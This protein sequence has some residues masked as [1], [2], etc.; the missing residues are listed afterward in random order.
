MRTKDKRKRWT[1]GRKWKVRRCIKGR[2]DDETM[3]KK[4]WG[5]VNLVNQCRKKRKWVK[6]TFNCAETKAGIW[7]LI[8]ARWSRSFSYWIRSH[9]LIWPDNSIWFQSGT[10]KVCS[11]MPVLIEHWAL[12][13]WKVHLTSTHAASQRRRVN[14]PCWTRVLS[15]GG[16]EASETMRGQQGQK[17]KTQISTIRYE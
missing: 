3:K 1:G 13:V 12:S 5:A 9:R 16:P 15:A 8:L 17:Q 14:V 10:K 7:E 11:Y 4:N 2:G 6:V